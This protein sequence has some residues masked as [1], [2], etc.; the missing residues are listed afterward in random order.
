[1]YYMA[2][3]KHVQPGLLISLKSSNNSS[4]ITLKLHES[5]FISTYCP[6]LPAFHI[7][8]NFIM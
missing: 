2:N 4:T 6:Q 8:L 7:Q 5:A 1:M 3:L